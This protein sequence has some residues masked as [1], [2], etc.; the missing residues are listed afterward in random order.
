M[1]YGNISK[2]KLDALLMFCELRD[3]FP[4]GLGK[5]LYLYPTEV[6]IDYVEGQFMVFI[7][8][9]LLDDSPVPFTENPQKT[10]VPIQALEFSGNF[11]MELTKILGEKLSEEDLFGSE[12]NF[13][14]KWAC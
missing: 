10:L 12:L 3:L 4:N 2:L 1:V 5:S 11:K 7:P 8:A 13:P 6:F 9:I 14:H